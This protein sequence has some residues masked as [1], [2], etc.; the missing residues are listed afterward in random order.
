MRRPSTI[1]N[2]RKDRRVH[3]AM[4]CA[5]S[6]AIVL[7][8]VIF[9]FCLNKATPSRGARHGKHRVLDSIMQRIVRLSRYI[10]RHRRSCDF[11]WL[12]SERTATLGKAAGDVGGRQATVAGSWAVRVACPQ[13]IN[14][15]R[16]PTVS[17]G[18]T[19]SSFVHAVVAIAKLASDEH[20]CFHGRRNK[21]R[22]HFP[23]SSTRKCSGP[24]P[25]T[26]LD[27]YVGSSYCIAFR[28]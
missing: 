3:Q 14:P 24:R 21:P 4:V 17:M 15:C 9:N 8:D 20:T 22:I 7:S 13:A 25:T 23:H 10:R 1:T 28:E 12:G 6:L 11:R 5:S 2:I 16:H 19:D 18:R 26:A 27:T